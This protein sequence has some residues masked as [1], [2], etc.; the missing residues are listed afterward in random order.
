MMG[1]G[2]DIEMADP[3]IRHGDG[4]GMADVCMGHTTWGCGE[5]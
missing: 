1:H 3:C 5:Q 4:M 2:G